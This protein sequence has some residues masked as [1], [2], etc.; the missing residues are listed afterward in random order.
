LILCTAAAPLDP[1]PNKNE[2]KA[3]RV[4]VLSTKWR[5]SGAIGRKMKMEIF[6]KAVF[7]VLK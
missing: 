4:L 6:Q 1:F 7:E 3:M 5:E 2:V